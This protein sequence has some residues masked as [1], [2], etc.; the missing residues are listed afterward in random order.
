M[1]GS[2]LVMLANADGGS[3]TPGTGFTEQFDTGGYY[4]G[5]LVQSTAAAINPQATITGFPTYSHGYVVVF[6]SDGSG[7]GGSAVPIIK[8]AMRR[9]HF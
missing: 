2:Y 1:N 6:K 3:Y 4:A 8:A 5:D 9:R 7:G